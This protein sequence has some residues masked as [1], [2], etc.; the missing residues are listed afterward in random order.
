MGSEVGMEQNQF[1]P[2]F[3]QKFGKCLQLHSYFGILEKS[4]KFS[5]KCY[6]IF[7]RHSVIESGREVG[8]VET[9]IDICFSCRKLKYNNSLP[10]LTMRNTSFVI[11]WAS[12]VFKVAL[13]SS[14][15]HVTE[16]TLN[17]TSTCVAM[18][19]ESVAA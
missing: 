18:P 7:F 9:S 2:R 17:L 12:R 10:D 4:G 5:R 1:R 16:S 11:S 14:D 6:E 3:E 13:A 8:T 15:S 19:L